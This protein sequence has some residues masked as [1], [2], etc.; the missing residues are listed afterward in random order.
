MKKWFSE[1]DVRKT[2]KIFGEVLAF[3]EEH[4][5]KSIGMVEEIIG[6]PH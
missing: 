1:S 4:E 6:C 3:I 5:V 2:E